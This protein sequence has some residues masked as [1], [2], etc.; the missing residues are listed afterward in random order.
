MCCDRSK[1]AF[2]H[3]LSSSGQHLAKLLLTSKRYGSRCRLECNYNMTFLYFPS[4][5]GHS[6]PSKS[7]S[8]ANIVHH[9]NV[10][11]LFAR[12]KLLCACAQT[13]ADMHKLPKGPTGTH[14]CT[15]LT[16][17]P[18]LKYFHQKSDLQTTNPLST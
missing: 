15:C 16:T 2:C 7:S 1:L 14:Y 8:V 18:S 5:Y 10:Y 3:I 6:L 17:I 12:R 11:K 13:R 9:S 4:S